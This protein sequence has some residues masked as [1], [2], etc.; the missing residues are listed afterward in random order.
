MSLS[1]VVVFCLATVVKPVDVCVV[2]VVVA[3][4]VYD[5]R[6]VVVLVVVLIGVGSDVDC[7]VVVRAR[8]GLG[9]LGWFGRFG[10]VVG[11]VNDRPNPY[12]LSSSFRRLA[13]ASGV[14]SRR[15]FPAAT[16]ALYL[17]CVRK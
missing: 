1:L 15:N 8:V 9:S 17:Q 2:G 4:S 3:K 12:S 13:R 6:L 11:G 16:A 7:R 14:S 5:L 10:R